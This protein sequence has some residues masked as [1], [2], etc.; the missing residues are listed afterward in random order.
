MSEEFVEGV[1]YT[2]NDDGLVV[3]TAD[4]LLRR[5]YCCESGCQNCPYGL[6]GKV[7][8]PPGEPIDDSGPDRASTG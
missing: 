7:P 6:D 5:G 1:D 2:I 4:Y 3:F 8:P